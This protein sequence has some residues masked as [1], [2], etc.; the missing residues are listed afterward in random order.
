MK[1]RILIILSCLVKGARW[2]TGDEL[3]DLTDASSVLSF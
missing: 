3:I 1:D 2:A